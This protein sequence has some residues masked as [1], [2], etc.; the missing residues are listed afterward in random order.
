VPWVYISDVVEA[1]VAAADKR[2]A[3]G[4]TYIVSD[5][6]SYRFADVVGSIARALGRT[7]GGRAVP[8]AVAWPIIA[9]VEIAA[10]ALGRDPPFT[11]HRL[12]SICGCRLVSIERARRELG[13]EPRVGLDE[14]IGRTVRWYLERG[15]V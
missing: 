13:Y 4:R 3:L 6:D 15:V 5:I 14:G 2:E 10:T 7:R 11:R 1:A 9:A 12:A 8:K